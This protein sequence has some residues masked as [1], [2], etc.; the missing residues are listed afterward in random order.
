MIDWRDLKFIQNEDFKELPD[1]AKHRLKGSIIANNF[2]QPFYVWED[3]EGIRWCLDG[4]HRTLLL[5]ELASEGVKIP[6]QLPAT[7]INCKDRK[8]AARLVLLFSSQYAKVT[9]EGLNTF[10]TL[11]DLDY[12][13]LKETI[14]LP[15]F[16]ELRYEQKFQFNEATEDDEPIDTENMPIVVRPGDVFRLGKHTLYCGSFLDDVVQNL[17]GD[18]KA[19][20]IFTDPPYNLAAN[21]FTNKGEKR[22]EDFAMAGGE[23]SD[24]EF[25]SFLSKIMHRSKIHSEE[26]SIHFIFMDWR[27]M[28]HMT[29]A[30]RKVYG[31]VIPKQL[32]VW[33]KNIGANGS[34]YRAKHELIFLYKNGDEEKHVSNI[35]LMDRIRYNV[36]EYPSATSLSNPDRNELKNHPTPKP[37]QMVA[38]AI[39]DTTNQGDLVIDWFMG[40]GTTII[41]AEVTGRVAFGTEIEPKYVQSDILRYIRHCEKNN[42]TPV[43]EHLNGSLY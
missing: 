24:E 15:E 34:F 23:M 26:G 30:G 28:W 42:I 1:E 11:Y 40:S 4:K 32:I 38:D 9:N 43:I 39:L 8:D 6:Y 10:L 41:A 21:Q 16:S 18:Q 33:N 3:T 22:F 14:D 13:E 36:W 31:S 35:D 5:E 29:E 27:H 19:R 25:V 37:V 12:T 17:L 20:I 2:T 7:F